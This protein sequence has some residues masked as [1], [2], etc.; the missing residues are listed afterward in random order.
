MLFEKQQY[1]IDCVRNIITALKGVDFKN[2]DFSSLKKNLKTIANKHSYGQFAINNK[3]R[4][5]ILMETGTGKTFT[6]LKAIFE[7]N[8]KFGQNKFIIILPRISIKLGVIQQ[9]K[10]TDEYFFNEYNKHLNYI[11]YPKDNIATIN[12]NFINSKELSILLLTNSSFNKNE[13]VIN[14]KFEGLFNFGST[15]HG[16]E[17]KKPIVIIDEP[18]LLK[19]EKTV[20]YLE[21]LDSLFIRF[22]ATYPTDEKHKL[23]NVV[24]SLDSIS[25]FNDYLVKQIG[26]NTVFTSSEE[27][28]IH[29]HNVV[30]RKKFDIFYNINEQLYKKEIR[31]NDDLG[32]KISI[33]KYRGKSVIKINKDEI[34]L[35]NKTTIKANTGNYQL[36]DNETEL[37]IKQAI[38]CHFEREEKLF[39]LGIK[40]L[41]LFFIPSIKDFRGDEPI[42]KKLFEKHYQ[43]IRKE[44]YDKSNNSEYKAYLD[45]DYQNGVLQVHE[46]YFSGDKG[47]NENKE[48]IGVN[49]ILNEKQKLLSFDT[50]LRFIFSV[51]ALQ[52]GWDN[53]N[54]FTICKLSHTDKDTSR[55]Q[56]VGRGLRIAV[57]QEGKR[58]T[59]NHLRE[60]EEKF[61]KIN[62]LD[63]LVSSQ[64]QSFIH[65]IQNEILANSFSIVGDSISLDILKDKGLS[66]I[67][68]ALIYTQLSVNNIIDSNGI[69]QSPVYDFLNA[70]RSIF[71]TI[72]D[73]RFEA[74]KKVFAKNTNKAIID[75]NKKPKMVKVRE[76]KWQEFKALWESI[77]KKSKIIYK[78][79]EQNKL[80]NNIIESFKSNDIKP[81]KS[82]IIKEVFNSKNNQIET[83]EDR[84][85]N[86]DKS[87]KY[88]EK[89]LLN[90]YIQE[91]TIQEKLPLNFVCKLFSKLDINK[92][93]NNPKKSK[94]LLQNI[95]KEEIHSSILRSVGYK[96]NKTSIYANPL[97]NEKGELKQEIKS[98]VL[99]QYFSDD[100]PKDEFLY[101]TVVYD[102]NI[103]KDSILND[104]TIVNKNKITVFAKLPKISIPTPYKNYNPDFAYLVEK[105][106]G[107]KLFLVV[108]TKGYKFEGDIPTEEQKKIKYAKIFFKALKD[109]M[110]DLDVKFKTRI[111][112]QGL[113]DI[114]N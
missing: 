112:S 88:F 45:K 84:S 21:K 54:I 2:N 55:R 6:Y 75:K 30:S 74:I 66:D 104:P 86:L 87:S 81:I 15:W 5:D 41:S 114:I 91:L 43:L 14:R 97:Q 1:Q 23:S 82:K 110:P 100:N 93:T 68:A 35:N 34:F 57:N 72:A 22:G 99:G 101:N 108:E 102:S 59:F 90:E 89:Q 78:D 105:K 53:P 79:I 20:Q 9:I 67:E 62:A 3:K 76:N 11:D 69:I 109:E 46:G 70:N 7:L 98:T 58:L 26:V 96:F 50:P 111:N 37:M 29:I 83:I 32:A 52:E 31:L 61:Y 92:F 40:T 71:N 85:I 28:A 103:E 51:W 65:Q 8:K 64:E 25:A 44:V 113:S 16:I 33:D 18:H 17:S 56:Q 77:N 36:N 4:L 38:K 73:A 10:F 106:N 39:N 12:Q 95:I 42:V 60:N 94:E 47:T 24:Y 13:A 49:I 48:S 19:G 107:K 80:I 63:M 27:S